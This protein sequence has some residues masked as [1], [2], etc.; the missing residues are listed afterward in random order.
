MES[1]HNTISTL[2]DYG[3][4]MEAIDKAISKLSSTDLDTLIGDLTKGMIGIILLAILELHYIPKGLS[5]LYASVI[6]SILNYVLTRL[7]T[8]T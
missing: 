8:T 6:N 4:S 3:F 2:T 5:T 7:G 1:D